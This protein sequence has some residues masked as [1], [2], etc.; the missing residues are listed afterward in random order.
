MENLADTN[1][2]G[3]ST[4]L[5]TL[6]NNNKT[7]VAPEISRSF[8]NLE[9]FFI[10]SSLFQQLC[11]SKKKTREKNFDTHLCYWIFWMRNDLSSGYSGDSNKSAGSGEKRQSQQNRYKAPNKGFYFLQT[12][13]KNTRH[14][15]GCF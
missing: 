12:G 3:D 8:Q 4:I 13:H 6:Y 5:D 9:R 1:H 10:S 15:A 2:C 11:Y 7:F 14:I